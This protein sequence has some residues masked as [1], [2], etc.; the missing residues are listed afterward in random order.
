M[1]MENNQ[2]IKLFFSFARTLSFQ[3]SKINFVNQQ[4]L[5]YVLIDI[6]QN[7]AI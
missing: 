4:P 2:K 5:S 7:N 6:T 3:Q 1:E